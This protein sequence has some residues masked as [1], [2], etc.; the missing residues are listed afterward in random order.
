MRIFLRRVCN[1]QFFWF[2]LL[3]SVAAVVIAIPEM[4]DSHLHIYFCDVGQGDGVIIKYRNQTVLI[5]GGPNESKITS[6]L[7]TAL[8]FWERDIDLLVLTHPH[9]DHVRG[10]IYAVDNYRIKAV[11]L[12]YTP[13]ASS[14][15]QHFLDLLSKEETKVIKTYQGQK[16]AFGNFFFSVLWPPKFC[17][18]SNVNYCSVVLYFKYKNFTALF[19]GDFPAEAQQDFINQRTVASAQLLKVPH[20]GARD[21]LAPA[22]LEKIKPSLAVVSVGKDNSFGHPHSSTLQLLSRVGVILKRTDLDGTVEV[23]SDGESWGW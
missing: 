2:I 9:A 1:S 7:N 15:Y 8:P 21:A 19:T 5:D 23:V 18:N 14:Q 6:C 17:L 3:T 4:P 20:Q 10:L 13:Y 22:F 12:A 16:L 11:L